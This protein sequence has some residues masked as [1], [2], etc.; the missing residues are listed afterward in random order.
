MP[1]GLYDVL[2]GCARRTGRPILARSIRQTDGAAHVRAF[3]A[4]S[5]PKGIK[6]PS[7][8]KVRAAEGLTPP[9]G[10]AA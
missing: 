2:V 4:G 7:V 10:K 5:H 6:D 8:A 3:A 9:T 1:D